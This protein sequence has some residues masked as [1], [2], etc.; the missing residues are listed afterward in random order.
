MSLQLTRKLEREINRLVKC[1]PEKRSASLMVL[2]AL[3]EEF[4]YISSEAEAWA[5][6]R[7]GLKPINIHELV[8]FYPMLR[9]YDPGRTVVR[10][11]RTLSCA[12]AGGA[13]LHGHICSRLGL[14]A[15]ASGLQRTKDGKFGVEFAEC[16][17]S[18][19]TGPVMMCN[20]D[21]Y[22]KV[23]SD[24]ADEILEKYDE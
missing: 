10:V 23:S 5:A 1:Y 14:D 4:G 19:G 20:D 13:K 18:C 6:A 9:S 3:Q 2:H 17:A 8:T 22:E 21:F 16:L 24:G 12:L 15:N 7:L 11:C